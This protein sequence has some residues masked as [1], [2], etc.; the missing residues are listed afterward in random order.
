MCNLQ[1]G[2]P[3]NAHQKFVI[4]H[5]AVLVRE[6]NYASQLKKSLGL[7]G[8]KGAVRR[9]RPLLKFERSLHDLQDEETEIQQQCKFE[10]MPKDRSPRESFVLDAPQLSCFSLIRQT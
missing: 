6:T 9:R 8:V 1:D 7:Q 5:E 10:N 3:R 2:I 4:N